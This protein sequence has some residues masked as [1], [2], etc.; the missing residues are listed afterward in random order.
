VLHAEDR[1]KMPKANS[2][3]FIQPEFFVGKTL[4][5]HSDFPETDY[6]TI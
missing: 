3:F 5:A 2:V 6:Q 1:E 4:H